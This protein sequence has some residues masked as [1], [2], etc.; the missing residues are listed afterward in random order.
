VIYLKRVSIVFYDGDSLVSKAIRWF[1]KSKVNHTA[2]VYDSEDWGTEI[3]I[4]AASNGV[5]A[6]KSSR[7]AKHKYIV[8]DPKAFEKLKTI[9]SYLGEFYDYIGIVKFGL[10]LLWWKLLKIK[11]RK[12]LTNTKGQFCSE[13]VA[14]YLISFPNIEI[15]SPQWTSPG[16]LLIVC[17]K[18][19]E[20]FIKVR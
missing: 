18:N 8:S 13:L 11:I 12:P 20:L 17:E 15:K 16:D 1:T 3:T 4:E 5:I 19:P 2:I 6:H 10:L 14:R 7:K 9:T